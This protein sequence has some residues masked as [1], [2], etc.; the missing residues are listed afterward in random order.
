MFQTEVVRFEGRQRIY[1]FDF[2]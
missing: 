2:G 1:W